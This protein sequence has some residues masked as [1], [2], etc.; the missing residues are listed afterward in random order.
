MNDL[1]TMD[2]YIYIYIG[3]ET[4]T[5]TSLHH[6]S[7]VRVYTQT[8][9]GTTND[10]HSYHILDFDLGGIMPH[11]LPPHCISLVLYKHYAA[12]ALCSNWEGTNNSLHGSMLLCSKQALSHPQRSYFVYSISSVAS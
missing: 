1:P 9:Q 11:P 2:R 12:A 10:I 8:N 3:I 7:R 5:I 6:W 4:P